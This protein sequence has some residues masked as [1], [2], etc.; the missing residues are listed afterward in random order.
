MVNLAVLRDNVDKKTVNMF[1]REAIHSGKHSDKKCPSCRSHLIEFNA[2]TGKNSVCLDICKKCQLIW[3]D[4]DELKQ[5][6]H[7]N[8]EIPMVVKQEAARA[9]V[10][11]RAE[12][13]EIER[14]LETI[15]DA[16]R[17]MVFL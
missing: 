1:W 6:P 3:F 16:L 11:L 9:E 13:R 5:F 15:K 12:A 7:H 10:L 2:V 14:K 4:Q 17:L 8:L